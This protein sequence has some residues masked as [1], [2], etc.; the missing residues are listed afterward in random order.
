[1]LWINGVQLGSYI[2]RDGQM[3][4]TV[5][6][7]AGTSLTQT[8]EPYM[9]GVGPENIKF[10]FQATG[11]YAVLQSVRNLLQNGEGAYWLR[12]DTI[13]IYHGSGTVHTNANNPMGLWV[14]V[15]NVSYSGD[16]QIGGQDLGKVTIDCTVKYSGVD[17][18]Y[19]GPW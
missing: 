17:S 6:E 5:C 14:V 19:A 9:T 8:Y 2:T 11:L 3:T 12:D 4:F 16:K 7:P 1:M 18:S 13:N 10:S 15:K